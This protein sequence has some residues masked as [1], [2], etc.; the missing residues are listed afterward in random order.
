[1]NRGS[2]GKDDDEPS[3]ICWVNNIRGLGERSPLGSVQCN[4]LFRTLSAV[5]V[6]LAS[7]KII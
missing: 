1:M 5:H 6:D 4:G 7:M 3:D 2:R